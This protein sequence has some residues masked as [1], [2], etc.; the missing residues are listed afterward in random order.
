MNIIY[1]VLSII[2]IILLCIIPLSILLC[3]ITNL[4]Y[5]LKHKSDLKNL[6]KI[7][8]NHRGRDTSQIIVHFFVIFLFIILNLSCYVDIKTPKKLPLRSYYN[9]M[10]IV[11][12]LNEATILDY[13]LEN[14]TNIGSIEDF[15]NSIIRRTPSVKLYAY[16]YDGIQTLNF[17]KSEIKKKNLNEI[18]NKPT[19]FFTNYNSM[20][21]VIKF[22]N[23]CSFYDS[24]NVL[25]SDCVILI[26]ANGIKPPN[27][28]NADR[29][30]L[31]IK[32][33]EVP[34]KI[35]PEKSLRR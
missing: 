34:A 6:F 14:K 5:I 21:S 15:M 7:N 2:A 17:S 27:V 10:K 19:I 9:K 29:A 3:F 13:K 33:D 11:S 1:F 30:Y 24:E 8:E 35:V 20:F 32:G 22:K 28:H 25:N 26:D 31:Y 4:L 23:G 18:E 16:Y 12:I